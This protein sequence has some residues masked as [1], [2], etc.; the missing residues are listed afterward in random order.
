MTLSTQEGTPTVAIRGL[1]KRFAG[2]L[3]LDD[4][5]LTILPGEVHG[6]LG[7][8]GSGKST[9]IKVLAGFHDVD[10]GELRVGGTPVDLPLGPGRP[11]ELGLQFVHQDLGLIGSL[12]VIDNLRIT[13]MAQRR[14]RISW[15]E[16]RRKARQ[17]FERYGIDLDPRL[18][19]DDAR[20]VQRAQLAI[21]RALEGI[22]QTDGQSGRARGLLVLDEPTVFL[23]RDEVDH[24]FAL[25]RE[26]VA[27][28][29]S[30]LF[31]SHDI[32]EVRRITDR[33]TVLRDGRVAGSAITSETTEDSL[34]ELI[35]GRRLA[36]LERSPTETVRTD[37][38]ATVSDLSGGQLEDVSF[39]VRSGEVLGIT[40]LLGSG[41]ED[42]PYFMFGA[43]KPDSGTLTLGEATYTLGQLSPGAAVRAGMALVPGDRK[44]D[45][46]LPSLSIT[47]NV[48]IQ[49]LDTHMRGGLLRRRAMQRY[50]ADLMERYDVRP[51]DPRLPYEALS[52]GNQQKALMGKWLDTE[53]K[54]LLLHEPTQGV[55]VGAREQIFGV[56]RTAAAEGRSVVVASS[57]HEQLEAVCQRVIVLGHG[58][59]VSELSG[60]EVTKDRIT[61]QCF[62]SLAPTGVGPGLS[63]PDGGDH[64]DHH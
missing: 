16:E 60:A 43:R 32:D 18:L 44:A 6:L 20:P 48:T 33:V 35:I 38:L 17:A 9:L 61:E 56:I 7:E 57:D 41:F 27:Q 62:G 4:V 23:P 59:V 39:E 12:S 50:A 51:R 14:L 19:V 24:L 42:V 36:R 40:G 26:V 2:I 30:V 46:S 54:L 45:G 15:G 3:A 31:V 58:H 5:D 1:T 8:N 13:D 55:D 22:A 34:V 53:P 29:N 47:D 37:V 21:I 52:G 64:V 11:Q 49:V 10:G 63:N 28:G 25:V